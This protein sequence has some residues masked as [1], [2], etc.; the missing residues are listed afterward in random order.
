M[1]FS[2]QF[3]YVMLVTMLVLIFLMVVFTIGIKALRTLKDAATLSYYRRIEPAL[4]NFLVTGERQP[5]LERLTLWMRDHFLAALMVERLAVLRGAGR[6]Y[7]LWLAGDLG[8]VDKYLRDLRARRRWTRARAAE[9]LGYLSGESAVTPISKLLGDEDETVRAVAARALARIGS[10]EAARLLTARL[11]DPSELN[12]LRAAENLE[13][14]GSL[15]V[16]PLSKLLD[17]PTIHGAV[18]AAQVLGNLRAREARNALKNT[19]AANQDVNVHAQATLALGKIGDPD[20]LPEILRAAG[21]DSWPVR[22]QAANALGFIGEISTIHTLENLLGDRAWWVRLNASRALA[23]MGPAGEE[24]LFRKLSGED[25]YARHRAAAALET[26]GI[27]RRKVEELAAPGKRGEKARSA[28]QAI[29]RA[30]ATNYLH[31]LEETLPDSEEARE[32]GRILARAEAE[33]DTQSSSADL[34]ET[35]EKRRA[36]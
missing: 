4:E 18:M 17:T 1:L 32:L 24:A 14:L 36:G 11:D 27:T 9:N 2:L 21:S 7:L 10:P 26:H 28:V 6:E 8:L 20:D 5:E 19:L 25:R 12:R 34:A 30:G 33:A 3:V 22:A 23:K 16:K 29:A 15:A 35:P 13:R 31:S